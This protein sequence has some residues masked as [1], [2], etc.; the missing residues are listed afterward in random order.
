MSGGFTHFTA[1]VKKALGFD[2][3]AANVL[4]HDGRRYRIVSESRPRGIAALF[5]NDVRRESRGTSA[6]Y[7]IADE[8]VYALCDLVCGNIAR[9][10]ERAAGSRKAFVGG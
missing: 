3:D 6:Y 8:A 4:E 7:C 9:R 10:F 1:V 5:I 2:L